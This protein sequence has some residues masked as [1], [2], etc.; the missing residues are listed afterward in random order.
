[1]CSARMISPSAGCAAGSTSIGA[2]LPPPLLPAAEKNR[3][4]T[5]LE[6]ARTVQRRRPQVLSAACL[7][8]PNPLD[9]NL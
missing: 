4:V 8:L 9:C 5:Y 7:S 6:G 2:A 3:E 1:M